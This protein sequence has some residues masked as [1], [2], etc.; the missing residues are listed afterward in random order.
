MSNADNEDNR[1]QGTYKRDNLIVYGLLLVLLIPSALV[2]YRETH[3][4]W[5][6]YQARFR[7]LLGQKF[8]AKA[9]Q[10]Y[11]FAINQIWLKETNTIDRCKTCHAGIEIEKLSGRDVPLVFRAH[12]D[13]GLIKNHPFATFGC[14]SCHGGK[15]YA[16]TVEDAHYEDAKGWTNTFLSRDLARRYG[17]SDYKTLP[18]VEINC[19]SCHI[20]QA[21]V[22]GLTYINKAKKLFDEKLCTC[23]HNFQGKG[24]QVGP[25]ITVEGDKPADLYDF[26]NIKDWGALS[27]SVFSWHFLHFKKPY[28]VTLN[29]LMPNLNLTDDEIRSLVM[30]VLSYKKVPEHMLARPLPAVSMAGGQGAKDATKTN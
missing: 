12:P 15:G 22:P 1:L 27:P 7:T 2:Y 21:Q 20:N 23:C 29:T 10:Q 18:L 30:L 17:F 26:S 6:D 8:G 14:T 9:E 13:P 16:L 28:A 25:D 4:E 3:P 24:G 11:A 19:N 5:M